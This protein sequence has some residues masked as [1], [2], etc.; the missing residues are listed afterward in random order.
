MNIRKKCKKHRKI[1]KFLSNLVIALIVVVYCAFNTMKVDANINNTANLTD[2]SDG[3]TVAKDSLRYIEYI[4]QYTSDY[5]VDEE[6]YIPAASYIEGEGIEQLGEYEGKT[7]V[8]MTGEQGYVTW[9]ID[10]SR[11]GLYAIAVEYY[12][13]RGYGNDIERNVTIDGLLPFKEATGVEFTRIYVDDVAN[14][15]GETIRPNQ[16][17]RPRWNSTYI[18]DSFG[19]FGDA[20]YFFLENGCH[21]LT[22]TS[23]KEPMVIANLKLI[24]SDIEPMSYEEVL[25]EKKSQGA[26]EVA[27]ALDNGVLYIQAEDTY[28]KGDPTLYAKS[29]ASSTRNQPFNY[30][31]KVLNSIGG[32]SWRYSNQWI[33]WKVTIPTSGFYHIGA[34]SK[35]NFVRDIY[36]NRALYIDGKIPFDKA[37]NIHFHYDDEWVTDE[38]G[39]EPYLFYL[40][41]GEHII[42][43]KAVPGDLTAI[44]ME[45]DYILENLNRINM[46]LLA[47]L[48]I[49]PDV[50]RD[51]QIGRY[52]PETVEALRENK[53]RL[54]LIYNQLVERTGKKDN[55]TSQL[56][57]LISLLNKMYTNPN[58]IASL[59]SRYRE[60]VGSFGNWIMTVREHPLLLDY[61]YIA[62]PSAKVDKAEDGFFKKLW[63]DIVAL[64]YSFFKDSS[65][66]SEPTAGGEAL[67]TITVWI[68]SGMTG[69]RDQ[70][71]ALNQMIQQS[72]TS[73]SGIA[74]N[75]QL[76]PENTI[77]M[78]T[79]AGRGPD[80][81][82]QAQMTMPVDFA[83]RNAVYDLTNFDDFNQIID[84]FFTSAA[85]PFEY[86]GGVY[87]LPETMSFPMLFYR[88]DI[89]QE[90]GIDVSKLTTWK[91]I[92]EILQ[93]LQSKNMNFALP[94]TMQTY[95][96]FLYQYGGEYYTVDE[97]SSNL[98]SKIALDAFEYW[99]DFYTVYSLPIDFS[100][101]NRFR[102]GEMP[103][104][105]SEYTTYNLLSISAP[106]IKGKWAMVELPGVVDED[107]NIINTAP[108]TSMGCMLMNSSKHKEAAWE[109][110]KWWTD[111]DSQYEFGKQLEAVM[112]AAARYNTANREALQKLPWSAVDRMGL[113]KQAEKLRGIPQIP[114]G[115]FTERN[116]NF[117]KLAVLNNLANPRETLSEYSEAITEEIAM[118]RKEFGLD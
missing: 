102:T 109:F 39:D 117:A 107:G 22:L 58:K 33:S 93:V 34:R 20:M 55:L 83:L 98:S 18:S 35:Q 43:L 9:Q 36:C 4:S 40:E 12:P 68:G 73:S 96:M 50:D 100:F 3:S 63:K 64:I 60:L 99:T 112:G 72:F 1:S 46:D 27:G 90:L 91:S 86:G 14:P 116:L 16:I 38:F 82:L 47:M 48:S 30:T 65:M 31:Q 5:F 32:E 7:D 42:T 78:A 115:Y 85:E 17:E 28:E 2:K 52:M 41:E 75:L 104:G 67:E 51:Y 118:K 62:E 53:E 37:A 56:E 108:I 84:R 71:M 114:G 97:K 113:M 103:I 23:V 6:I 111:A 26:R 61:L 25:R 15:S 92:T 11:S 88:T 24:S 87:A 89:L 57:Q 105:I 77:L 81:V 74:V 8:I 49:N 110:M 69:G 59:Y 80:V 106:E 54:V 70:A 19:Y 21:T 29:D 101:E 45:A 79:L 44:L 13:V 10:V 66:I 95:S 76:V 94:A